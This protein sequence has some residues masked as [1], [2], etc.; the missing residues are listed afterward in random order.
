MFEVK[1][2]FNYIFLHVFSQTKYMKIKHH[3]FENQ[4]KSKK[5]KADE[6]QPYIFML[7]FSMVSFC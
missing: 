6:L 5:W 4:H 7:L 3:K 2:M 1:K